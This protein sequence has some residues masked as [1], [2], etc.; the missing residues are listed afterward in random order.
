[1]FTFHALGGGIA[2]LIIIISAINWQSI[3]PVLI[4]VLFGLSGAIYGICAGFGV[5]S[6]LPRFGMRS[7]VR[8]SGLI[9]F[10]FALISLTIG[11]GFSESANNLLVLFALPAPLLIGAILGRLAS[12]LI[13]AT[14]Q[15]PSQY[16]QPAWAGAPVIFIISFNFIILCIVWAL[17]I[18]DNFIDTVPNWLDVSF[19]VPSGVGAGIVTALYSGL[20]T[21]DN[22]IK[23][24]ASV[25][26][27]EQQFQE[28]V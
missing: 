13:S 6:I 11:A 15:F 18:A 9:G 17:V 23:G 4:H 8:Y 10:G 20:I 21:F 7:I 5:R 3:P 24:L 1:M 16:G 14:G 26:A 28:Q 22:I 25:K 27:A 12:N 2:G 19:V